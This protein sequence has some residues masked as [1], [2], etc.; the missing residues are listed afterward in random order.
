MTGS[1]AQDIPL[2]MLIEAIAVSIP[3]IPALCYTGQQNL[4]FWSATYLSAPALQA[5]L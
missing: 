1:F 5:A 3:A 2:L 4:L